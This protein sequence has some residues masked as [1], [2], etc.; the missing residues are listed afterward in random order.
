MALVKGLA[1]IVTG[2][3]TGIGR[4]TALPSAAEGAQVVVSDSESKGDLEPVS[5]IKK[6]GEAIFVAA[7]VSK[8]TD[9]SALM[10]AEIDNMLKTGGH[11]RQFGVYC[12]TDRFSRFVAVCGY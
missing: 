2:A 3:A 10:Q 7:D 8:H 6:S 1:A 4:A 5:L 12:R 9:V 11:H